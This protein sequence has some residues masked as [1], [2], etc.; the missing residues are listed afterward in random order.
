M[1]VSIA[2]TTANVSGQTV[3]LAGRDH[4]ITGSWTFDRDPSAP[5]TVSAGSAVVTNLDAD[6]VDGYEASALAVLAENETI[7][8]TWTMS[9]KLT[10]SKGLAFPATQVASTGANDL[11]DYEEGSW[12]PTFGGS[13][14]QSGQAYSLQVGRYI[15]VGKKVFVE[16]RVT[17]STL[18]TLTGSVQIQGLPFTS[19][20]VSSLSAACNCGFV[21]N[22]AAAT[23]SQ[24]GGFVDTNATTITLHGFKGAATGTS[25]VAQA[26]FTATTSIIF[27][28]TYQASA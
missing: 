9:E 13:G 16:G 22:L 12:T 8:G 4:T 27:S 19:E 5:F 23:F 2:N 25:A 14:G 21:A 24:L 1:A 26:D 7:S 28:A 15:K 11:D 3:T 20:N 18:G 17:L 6:K 10:V